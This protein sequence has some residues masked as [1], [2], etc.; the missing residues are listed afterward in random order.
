MKTMTNG[1]LIALFVTASG[2]LATAQIRLAYGVFGTGG[3]MLSNSAYAAAGTIGQTVIGRS[4]GTTFAASA[5]FWGDGGVILSVEDPGTTEIPAEYALRQNYP[6]PFNPSTTVKYELPKASQVNLSVCD[7]LGREVT[8]LVD[9]R[10]EAGAHE[11]RFDASG[12]SSGV[13]FCRLKA[14]DFVQTRKL[15]LLR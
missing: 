12:L 13:Y 15:L 10:E 11:V 7:M 4:A 2:N 3:G 9:E 8:T 14:G 5:G 6:N 1:L